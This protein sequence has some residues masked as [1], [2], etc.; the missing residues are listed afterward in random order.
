MP[1]LISFPEI[2]SE[3]LAIAVKPILVQLK[4][5]GCIFFFLFTSLSLSFSPSS[6]LSLISHAIIIIAWQGRGSHEQTIGR[7]SKSYIFLLRLIRKV[8]TTCKRMS[9][10]HLGHFMEGKEGKKWVTMVIIFICLS[11]KKWIVDRTTGLSSFFL[12][13]YLF[14]YLILNRNI[15]TVCLYKKIN[16]VQ[17]NK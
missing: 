6:P 4:K 2:K 14:I 9:E 3:V 8:S 1:Y 16:K 17:I 13:F 10:R 15:F 5:R 7:V 11:L 12:C